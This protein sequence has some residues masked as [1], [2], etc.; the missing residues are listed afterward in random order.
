M[1]TLALAWGAVQ[2]VG[3]LDLVGA[4]PLLEPTAHKSVPSA[5]ERD[6][7]SH[8]FL[9]WFYWNTT[10]GG[11]YLKTQSAFSLKGVLVRDMSPEQRVL[12]PW[13][14]GGGERS[15]KWSPRNPNLSACVGQLDVLGGGSDINGGPHENV[16]V[17][18]LGV[19]LFGDKVSESVSEKRNVLAGGRR[20]GGHSLRWGSHLQKRAVP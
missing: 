9:P 4:P 14:W 6:D 8:V 12:R 11:Y 17:V 3:P 1:P 7:L 10:W 18:H 2:D 19:F 15:A 13:A 16:Q 20:L 5:A